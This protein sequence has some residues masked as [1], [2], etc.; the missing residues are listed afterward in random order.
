MIE[1]TSHRQGAVLNHNHGIET[2]SSLKIRVEGISEAGRPV[3]VNGVPAE[4]DGR[5]F[6]ADVEL[7]EKFNNITA[8]VMTPTGDYSQSLVL[9]WDKK[10]FKRFNC[11]IDD[12]SFLFME[13]TR[14][15]P[16]R[17]F[18]HFYLAALKKIHEETGLKVTLN[19]F[20]RNDHD[21]DGYLLSEMPDI[22]KSEFEDQ[23][24]WLRF[25]FHAYSE[26]PDRP[27][28]E[29][30]A[31]EFS[32]DY[33]LIRDEIIR[34]AGEKSFIVPMI[35]HWGNIHSA[36]AAEY[37]RKG[38][39]I[40]GKS[41]RPCVMGGPSLADRQKGG[42]MKAVENRAASRDERVSEYEGFSL[43]YD[44][45]EENSYLARH[46]VYYNPAIDMYIQ[47]GTVCCNLLTQDVIRERIAAQLELNGKYGVETYSFASHEQYSFP[48]YPNYIPDHL[49]RIALTARLFHEAG[50]K[51]VFYPEGLFGNTAWGE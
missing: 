51:G 42:N 8:T 34:F 6:R 43:Y 27:Y 17:A 40:Y 15:K 41:M 37:R 2:E 26:F 47:L 3:K 30:T 48:F 9:V 32:R 38:A 46:K 16:A 11:Y 28:I 20:F 13:L 12:H 14:Q 24:D 49:D 35:V 23:S 1:I 50:Y 21:P 4:M 33:D 31:E 36:V 39:M 5:I 18:D 22:W 7:K 25:S 29:A 45:Q 19:S 10:S 44:D